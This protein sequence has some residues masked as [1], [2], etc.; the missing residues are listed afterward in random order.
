MFAPF[1]DVGRTRVTQLINKTNQFNLTTRRYSEAQ[2]EAF[3]K[4]NSGLTLQVR[5]IDKFGDNGMVSVVICVAEDSEWIIDTWLMSCR[6]LN[7]RLEE[8]TLNWIVAVAKAAGIQSLVGQY[9]PT[10]R[11]GIVK[12][13]YSRLDFDLIEA[14]AS[15]TV[16]RLDIQSYQWRPVPIRASGVAAPHAGVRSPIET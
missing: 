7:R 11:N 5:L 2:V 9:L 13:H 14:T 16:W 12:E 8:A 1:D 4:S 3:E 6:V 15:G 10:E